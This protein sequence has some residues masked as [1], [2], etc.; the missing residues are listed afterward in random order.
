MVNPP[1]PPDDFLLGIDGNERGILQ[2]PLHEPSTS[3]S[4]SPMPEA[5]PQPPNPLRVPL[6]QGSRLE[7]GA[8][9]SNSQEMIQGN[10]RGGWWSPPSRSP[11]ETEF[12]NFSEPLEGDPGE[13]WF[14]N[15]IDP[16]TCLVTFLTE[17]QWLDARSE[18]ILSLADEKIHLF[19]EGK[20]FLLPW[21]AVEV[22]VDV[23]LCLS[24]GIT[25]FRSLKGEVYTHGSTLRGI[26]LPRYFSKAMDVRTGTVLFPEIHAIQ[27]DVLDDLEGGASPH[28]LV[29]EEPV[30]N[31]P[32]FCFQADLPP[33]ERADFQR[34]LSRPSPYR[35]CTPSPSS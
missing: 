28:D 8:T 35:G 4:P 16:S 18:G 11:I 24:E 6:S 26:L 7:E 15:P 20:H 14:S 33:Q 27:V 17:E 1:S 29:N 30:D 25:I 5:L 9:S 31:R 3:Q 19:D 23:P 21:C 22:N 32:S 10:D 12:G 2:E 13:E 34:S